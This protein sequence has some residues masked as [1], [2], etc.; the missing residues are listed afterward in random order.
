MKSIILST[1]FLLAIHAMLHAQQVQVPGAVEQSFESRY[2]HAA[3]EKWT[4]KHNRFE[5]NFALNGKQMKSCFREDGTWDHTCRQIQQ[6]ELPQAVQS[7]IEKTSIAG[8]IVD[9]IYEWQNTGKPLEYHI[10]FHRAGEK[11]EIVI[12]ALGKKI[13]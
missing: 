2:P 1:T 11:K 5:V 3:A 4:K 8:W 9:E 13:S 7:A 12:T 10:A 6:N